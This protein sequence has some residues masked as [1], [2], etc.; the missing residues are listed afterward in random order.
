MGKIFKKS[1]EKEIFYFCK[2]LCQPGN[3]K[4][5]IK[6]YLKKSQPS[7]FPHLL[8][9]SSLPS[10][11][12]YA[13]KITLS[14][15]DENYLLRILKNNIRG[16]FE[17]YLLHPEKEKYQ[18][19]FVFFENLNRDF[20]TDAHG[21]IRFGQFDLE[22]TQLRASLCPPSA[23]F[24]LELA[25]GQTEFPLHPHFASSEMAGMELLTE[26][27]FEGKN[28]ILK[29]Q[30]INLPESIEIKKITMVIDEQEILVA[31]PQKGIAIFELPENIQTLQ[32][33]LYE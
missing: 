23:I 22:I 31:Q 14:S 4:N 7:P 29:V 21:R 11:E 25:S 32:I 26:F 6:L 9:F 12:F 10:F 1:E 15:S 13:E 20:L 24:K 33:N 8:G 19:V 18:Y 2:N 27:F 5:R 16:E 28:R 30:A 3:F 17:A